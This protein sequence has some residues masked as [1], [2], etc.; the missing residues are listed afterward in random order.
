MNKILVYHGTDSKFEYFD[1]S[2][3]SLST[4]SGELG[5]GF[6]FSTDK[7]ICRSDKYCLKRYLEIKN[8]LV[9]KFNKWSDN[10]KQL[11]TDEIDVDKSISSKLL[12]KKLKELGYDSV[13]LDYSPVKYFH[14]EILVF[15]NKQIFK[16]SNKMEKLYEANLD[17]VKYFEIEAK[18]YD[19][20]DKFVKKMKNLKGILLDKMDSNDFKNWVGNENVKNGKIKVYRGVD[21]INREFRIGDFV[22]INKEYAKTYGKHVIEKNIPIKE[23]AYYSGVKGG[24]PDL[25][26]TTL[27]GS[28][29]TELIW[30]GKPKTKRQLINIWN[31]VH[32]KSEKI[33]ESFL[34]EITSFLGKDLDQEKDRINVKPVEKRQDKERD[35]IDV[36]DTKSNY[37][38]GKMGLPSGFV[39]RLV[40]YID[41]FFPKETK[42]GNSLGNELRK[43]VVVSNTGN[44]LEKTKKKVRDIIYKEKMKMLD[45]INK[46]CSSILVNPK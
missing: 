32:L 15:D 16:E 42:I 37:N 4:D 45:R 28:Q 25:V 24:S 1:Y 33:H 10:K 26:G 8:P 30:R 7:N 18:K 2:K 3:I 6:Y 34:D 14:K 9:L 22:T 39:N 5:A 23:L 36:H 35:D 13:I 17:D 40:L 46:R 27:G 31:N 11:V 43:V 20:V 41:N 21:N 12:T 44:E 29:P 38:D 19:T